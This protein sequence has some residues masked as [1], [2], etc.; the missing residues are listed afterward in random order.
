MSRLIVLIVIVLG[1]LAIA[2]LVRLYELSSKLRDRREEDIP[3]RDNK[4]NATLLL[5]FMLFLFIG[6][7]WLMWQYGWTGRGDA[8]SVHGAQTDWLLNLN[9]WIIIIV[10]FITNALLFGFAYKYVRKPGVKAY[11]FPHDNRLELAW[12]VVPAIVLAIIIILGLRSWNDQ[13]SEPSKEAVRIELFSKQFAWTVRMSGEDNKL[14]FFDYKLTNG[15]NPLALM[16]SATIQDAIDSMEIGMGGIKDLEA[17]LNDRTIMLIPEER[18]LMETDLDR[19]ERLI[20]M[21]YQMKSRHDAKLDAQSWDDLVFSDGDTLV[22]KQNQEYE[23][24]F[25]A[26]DVIHSAY[27]PHFRAQMNTVPGMTTR[28][29]FTPSVTTKQMR[30]NMND[31]KFNYILMCNKICGG[32]HYKMKLMV[33]VLSPKE[34]DK[35]YLGVSWKGT[36]EQRAA[37]AKLL[38][39][40]PNADDITAME[41]KSKVFKFTYALNKPK[42]PA[43]TAPEGGAAPADSTIV[44]GAMP[45]NQVV[46]TPQGA[47]A[48]S[49]D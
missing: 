27:F 10:F 28:F 32:A 38:G 5:G 45:Q 11:Y 29:K 35:W 25:R 47:P 34:Y 40:Q 31:S 22:L 9:F 3:N 21:L 4:L 15:N 12:T 2:Q 39:R 48:Q 16:T 36:K 14:G 8:A 1:V 19:K 37:L 6:F 41:G 18:E 23:F 46:A 13:T 44:G 7:I 49:Q 33:I 30:V 42:E 43:A 17:K 24:N 26:K 20:R